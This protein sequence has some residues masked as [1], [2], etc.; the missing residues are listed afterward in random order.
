MAI[1][2]GVF[3]GDILGSLIFCGDFLW[4]YFMAIFYGD[5]DFLS[6]FL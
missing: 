2:C 5:G 6:R 4:R 1:F 3:Y